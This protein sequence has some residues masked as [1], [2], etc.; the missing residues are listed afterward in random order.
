MNE[1]KK[2]SDAAQAIVLKAFAFARSQCGGPAGGWKGKQ[3]QLAQLYVACNENCETDAET[4]QMVL[5][6]LDS[7]FGEAM[8]YFGNA[9]ANAQVFAD[10]KD[11]DG[12]PLIVRE[13]RA[14]KKAN[15]FA[16]FNE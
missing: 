9:S 7:P 11:K 3:Q 12:K 2:I 15:I 5:D 16:G 8:A 14:G 10:T 6:V 4:R 1:P 13:A